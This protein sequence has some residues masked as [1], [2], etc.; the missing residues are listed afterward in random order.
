MKRAL[1]SFALP[2]CT[3]ALIFA[4]PEPA[5]A[6][7]PGSILIWPVNPVIQGDDR[8]AALWLENPGKTPVTLQ[9]R[10]YAWAQPDGRDAYAQQD[11]VLGTPP[12]VTIQPGERQLVRLTRTT[13]P[14]AVAEKPYRVIVDEI[15]TSDAPTSPGAAV[16]FRMRYSLPLFSYA[17]SAAREGKA[18]AKAALPAPALHWRSSSD[19]DGTF[20]E[21]R[22]TGAG[23]ARLTDVAFVT[24]SRRNTVAEGLLG[25]VLPGATMRWPLPRG[26][27]AS[28][29][30]SAAINGH[31]AA[32]IERVPE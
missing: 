15:P 23:H 22:N 12:I 2:A 32:R 29:D 10:V 25:Y 20:L 28:G 3:L 19:A 18:K 13:P 5:F 30:L 8:A 26:T 27:A 24:G 14:P 1:L 31:K 6:Q 9:V 4:A 16:S 7:Q 21:I 11:E 17:Q